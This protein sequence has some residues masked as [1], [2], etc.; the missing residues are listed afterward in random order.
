[1]KK[2]KYSNQLYDGVFSWHWHNNWNTPIEIGSK[3]Q[4]IENK[5]DNLLKKKDFYDYIYT[6][7]QF[8]ALVSFLR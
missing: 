7:A 5:F 3:W 8:Y 2:T 1:M 4:I 6:S